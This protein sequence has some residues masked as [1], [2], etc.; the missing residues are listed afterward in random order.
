[1]FLIKSKTMKKIRIIYLVLYTIFFILF[2]YGRE[3][4]LFIH[5]EHLLFLC[6][7]ISF[8]GGIIAF[9]LLIR[10]FVEEHRPPWPGRV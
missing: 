3:S 6:A 7:L 4:G 8:F 5:H 2:L 1:M 9:I 10:I